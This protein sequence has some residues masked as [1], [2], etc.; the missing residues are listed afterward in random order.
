MSSFVSAVEKWCVDAGAAELD[1]LRDEVE[2]ICEDLSLPQS[3][4]CRLRSVLMRQQLLSLSPSCS[5]QPALQRTSAV[6]AEAVPGLRGSFVEAGLAGLVELAEA[7]CLDVGTA[8]LA[9]II[10]ELEDLCAAL[11][12][13]VAQQGKL[14]AALQVRVVGPSSGAVANS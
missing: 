13:D 14:R 11:G 4:H 2:N 3:E 5:A 1:E 7:W 8:F 9:E 6:G 10:D 12:V